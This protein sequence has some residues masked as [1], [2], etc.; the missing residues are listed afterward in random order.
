MKTVL[1]TKMLSLPQKEL[2]L[3]SGLGLVEYDALKIEL[4][5]VEIPFDCQNYIFTSKN[6]VKA[7]LNQTKGLDYSKFNIF[8]VGGKTKQRSV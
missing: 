6:A 3:N 5:D 2:F 1:S 8:C 7:F 4:L